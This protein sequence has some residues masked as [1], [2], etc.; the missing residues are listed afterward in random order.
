MKTLTALRRLT[1]MQLIRFTSFVAGYVGL[2]MVVFHRLEHFSWIDSLYFVIV[3][4]GTV[5]YGDLAP[6][7]P[8]GRLFTVFYIVFGIGVFTLF[9]KVLLGRVYARQVKWR[10]TRKR[11]S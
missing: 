9:A 2:G 5:G 11:R 1:Q 8:A 4:L 3:T 10:E 6:Q 7:T